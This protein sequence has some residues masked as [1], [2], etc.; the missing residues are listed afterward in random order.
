[1]VMMMMMTIMMM[2]ITTQPPLGTAKEPS[3]VS[4]LVDHVDYDDDSSNFCFNIATKIYKIG[5]QQR[6]I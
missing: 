2:M 1:M 3:L 6:I 4:C 5:R